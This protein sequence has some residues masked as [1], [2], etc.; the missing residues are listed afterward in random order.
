MTQLRS[1]ERF[2]HVQQFILF[3]LAI[4]VLFAA[5][6]LITYVVINKRYHRHYD[7]KG[8]SVGVGVGVGTG[9]SATIDTFASQNPST[10]NNITI[11][12]TLSVNH[13]KWITD[14]QQ[15]TPRY[16][17]IRD[18]AMMKTFVSLVN[19]GKVATL[20]PTPFTSSSNVN[21]QL[22]VIADPY[23]KNA[24]TSKYTEIAVSPPGYFIGLGKPDVVFTKQCSLD[25]AHSTVGYF[26]DTDARFIRAILNAHR[27]ELSTVTLKRVDISKL[28]SYS[29]LEAFLNSVDIV[30]T[31]VIPTS[32]FHSWLLQQPIAFMG[33]K[34]MDI[35]R[36]NLF[37]PYVTMKAITFK[38]DIMYSSGVR[39]MVSAAEDETLL[40]T[41][42][43]SLL[44]LAEV[45]ALNS[46]KETFMTRLSLD[47]DSLDPGYRCYGDAY[48]F[49]KSLCESP[50]NA[51]GLPKKVYTTWD[52]P[53]FEDSDCPFY[54]ANPNYN[55]TRGG[56][57]TA[58]MCE[59]P[60][61]VRRLSY[62]KYNDSGV[63]APFCYGCDPYDTECCKENKD[64]AFPNDTNDRR[65]AQ[66]ET[67][68]PMK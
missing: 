45:Q 15:I 1:F 63:Y 58:G 12:N 31:Y 20:I 41:M 57:G 52:I 60:I 9:A 67:S 10:R 55:N 26:C 35:N 18:D 59:M 11:Y 25:L 8:T 5:I 66:K 65:K 22:M 36:I 44:L 33:F 7:S 46:N 32:P 37:Y 27:I 34:K 61:G 21:Q 6:L 3:A 23:E 14:S 4:I 24:L 40:P 47:N 53:C 2:E 19:T 62:R 48:I 51:I 39:A 38:K 68:I 28:V 13:T 29:Y 43:V 56:C 50:Y 49:T 64:Y 30:I 17:D 42:S 16:I 54:K